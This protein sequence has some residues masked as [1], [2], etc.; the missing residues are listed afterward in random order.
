MNIPPESQT[1]GTDQ[2]M[3]PLGKFSAQGKAILR[4]AQEEARTFRHNYIGTEHLLLGLLRGT[5]NPATA[6]LTNLGITLAN[7]R[8]AV[9]RIIGYGEAPTEG[10]IPPTPRTIKAISFSVGEAERLKQAL[11]EPE[12]ILLGLL[13][14]GEGIAVGILTTFGA[15][16][17]KVRTQLFQAIAQAG[18][19]IPSEPAPTKSNVVACRI[20]KR[21]LDAIDAL[22]EAGIRSTRSDAASWLIHTGIEANKPLFEKVNGTVAEIRRLRAS[23]QQLVQET[24]QQDTTPPNG[25]QE[26]PPKRS[27][28]TQ[29]ESEPD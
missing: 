17:D 29:Q 8:V 15:D 6:T 7:T 13:H 24:K 4:L 26:L 2:M 1:S 11:V 19:V 25:E 22:I 12:H 21:D 3:I 20:D 9:E 5:E 18:G 14:E 27:A 10:K 23:M 16:A 28:Q